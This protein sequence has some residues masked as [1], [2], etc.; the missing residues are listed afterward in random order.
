VVIRFCTGIA[1]VLGIVFCCG[2]ALAALPVPTAKQ[3]ADFREDGNLSIGSTDLV[4]KWDGDL[5]RDLAHLSITEA[6]DRLAPAY[7]LSRENMGELAVLWLI[8]N[9][10]EDL[11]DSSQLSPHFREL[12]IRILTL[13]RVTNYDPLVRDAAIAILTAGETCRADDLIELAR[14]SANPSRTAWD[15]AEQARCAGWYRG[16]Q[17]LAPELTFPVLVRLSEGD[18]RNSDKLALLV[19]LTSDQGLSRI[20]A[21]DRAAAKTHFGWML[22][23]QF[24]AMGMAEDGLA[25]FDQLPPDTRA[26]FTNKGLSA[27]TIHVDGLA[28]DLNGA[29]GDSFPLD[30]AEALYLSGR[31]GEAEAVFATQAGVE[32]ARQYVDCR[33]R[34]TDERLRDEC[35][36]PEDTPSPAL[37]I[38]DELLHHETDDPYPIAEAFLT[39]MNRPYFSGTTADTA[40]KLFGDAPVRSICE[41]SRMRTVD[42]IRNADEAEQTVWEAGANDAAAALKSANIPGWSEARKQFQGKLE[43]LIQ[44]YGGRGLSSVH[45]ADRP[46]PPPL[47]AALP[48]LQRYTGR[49]A[50]KTPYAIQRCDAPGLKWPKG[51]SALPGDFK[52]MRIERQDQRVVVISVSRRYDEGGCSTLGGYWVHVSEDGGKSWQRPLYTGLID[53]YPYEVVSTSKMPMINGDEL[54]IEVDILDADPSTIAYPLIDFPIRR[55]ET[56]YYVKLPLAELR[57]D[58]DGD[59]ITDI[60]ENRLL[61]DPHNPDTN[62][63]GIPDGIDPLPN[64]SGPPSKPVVRELVKQLIQPAHE[65]P[66]PLA[67]ATAADDPILVAGNPGDFAGLNTDHMILVY[68]GEQLDRLTRV[69][70]FEGLTLEP[71]IYSRAGDR[72]FVRYNFGGGGGGTLRAR[73]VNGTWLIDRLEFWIS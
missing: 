51:L 34:E 52:P 39:S 9:N 36:K 17:A 14:P 2:R 33:M 49:T 59:G 58:S 11:V 45:T 3:V 47:F 48:I 10:E 55:H 68:S 73:L 41:D 31:R 53:L 21:Q 20:D 62:G 66:P 28:L 56:G 32:K 7:K 25:V 64:L 40:C 13:L 72:G 61:L 12:R 50:P 37:L 26:A 6:S 46:R 71:I 16:V 38:M 44:R 24:W 54:D 60:A 18:M 35:A 57:R 67:S 65:A 42:A 69:I 1:L 23:N 29:M 70:W 30:L 27:T 43:A 5:K 19:Y 22:I 8:A 4:K 15:A 63:N